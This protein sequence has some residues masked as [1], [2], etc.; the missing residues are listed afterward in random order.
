MLETYFYTNVL[1]QIMDSIDTSA[2]D[3]I[4]SISYQSHEKTYVNTINKMLMDKSL[5]ADGVDLLG[6]WAP[7]GNRDTLRG[8]TAWFHPGLM[9]CSQCVYL[10]LWLLPYLT[11]LSNVSPYYERN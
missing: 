4:G 10:F 11:F 8:H 1:G 6:F 9:V 3:W 5:T 2:V 7:L